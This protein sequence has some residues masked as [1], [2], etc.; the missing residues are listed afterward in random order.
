[1]TLF[2]LV[3]FLGTGVVAAAYIPQILHLVKEHCS[4][5]I[6]MNAYALW[7]V[8]SILFLIHAAMI[9]DVVFVFAQIVNLAAIGAIAFCVKKYARQM[10]LRHLQEART[11]RH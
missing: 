4:A 10:C 8:A 11:N 5:G 9:R 6:S 1:M 3:G 2:Q 7:W